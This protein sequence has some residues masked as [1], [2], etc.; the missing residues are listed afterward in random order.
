MTEL[1]TLNRIIKNNCC[2]VCAT[3][4]KFDLKKEASKY[5]KDLEEHISKTKDTVKETIT[6]GEAARMVM[7]GLIGYIKHTNNLKKSDLK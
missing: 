5:I 1:K 2:T 6:D 7:K 3:M 4:L